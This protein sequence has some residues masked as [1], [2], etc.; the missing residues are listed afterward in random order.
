VRAAKARA[1]LDGR[2]NVSFQDVE[3]AAYPVLRHRI[4]VSF[5][6]ISEGINEDTV[7]R[8]ILE[9]KKPKV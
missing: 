5:D 4:I 2:F 6:A 7:I 9:A 1:F 8:Q 3:E